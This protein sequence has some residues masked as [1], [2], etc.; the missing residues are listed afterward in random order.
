MMPP[1]SIA[2]AKAKAKAKAHS[3]ISK[4]A[5]S[6]LEGVATAQRDTRAEYGRDGKQAAEANRVSVS[7]HDSTDGEG[8]GVLLSRPTYA[9]VAV[10]QDNANL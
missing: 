1:G 4:G 9:L 3:E 2:A 10:A 8:C 7:S 5:H 6:A